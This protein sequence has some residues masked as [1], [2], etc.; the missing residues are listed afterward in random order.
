MKL[1]TRDLITLSGSVIQA[2]SFL[3]NMQYLCSLCLAIDARF[4]ASC[5][6]IIYE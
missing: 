2:R 6:G 3:K 5:K 4:A 1:F